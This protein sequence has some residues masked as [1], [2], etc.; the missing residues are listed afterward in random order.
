MICITREEDEEE[1]GWTDNRIWDEEDAL[2]G[3][4]AEEY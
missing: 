4:T 1:T 2:V 3:Q